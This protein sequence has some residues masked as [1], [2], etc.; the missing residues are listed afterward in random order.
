MRILICDDDLFFRKQMMNLVGSFLSRHHLYGVQVEQFADGYALLKDTGPKDIVFLDMEMPGMNGIHAGNLLR[1]RGEKAIIIVVTSYS[2]YLDD[3]MRFSAF[4]YLSKP[5]DERRFYRNLEDA[6]ERL[7]TRSV[8]ILLENGKET[9][10][11]Q[12]KDILMVESANRKTVV[13][14]LDADYMSVNK[15][16]YW[17]DKLPR[18]VFIMCHRSFIVNLEYVSRFNR[19]MVYLAKNNL[20][21]Y[22]TRRRHREFCNAF[23]MFLRNG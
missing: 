17:A 15:I 18:H 12:S 5:I 7:R 8:K 4:R 10:V 21:A 20:C 9:V 19:E 23:R 11:V 2:E 22:L 1:K 16:S 13:H 14:C 3:A 6:L